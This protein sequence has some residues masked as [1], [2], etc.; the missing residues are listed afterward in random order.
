MDL[1]T[2]SVAIWELLDG[3]QICEIIGCW[4]NLCQPLDG[5]QFWKNVLKVYEF[6][7]AILDSF[8]N[9]S[10]LIWVLCLWLPLYNHCMEPWVS[11]SDQILG[12]RLSFPILQK[13]WNTLNLDFLR[14]YVFLTINFWKDF[15]FSSIQDFNDVVEWTIR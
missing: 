10:I 12:E 5:D 15:M 7:N 9:T 4:P 14:L 13:I 11:W 6:L 3:S 8:F 1:L 2:F